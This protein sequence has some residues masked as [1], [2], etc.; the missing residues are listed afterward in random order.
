MESQHWPSVF[1][2]ILIA[3]KLT[4]GLPDWPT[5]NYNKIKSSCI[6]HLATYCIS[7]FKKSKIDE[8]SLNE[9]VQ[10]YFFVYLY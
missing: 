3:W 2:Y 6:K 4:M 8:T 7:A 1:E 10:R 5:N 9:I